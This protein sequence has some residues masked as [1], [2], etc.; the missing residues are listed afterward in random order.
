[1]LKTTFAQTTFAENNICSKQH[2]LKQYL[3]KTTFAQNN[4]FSKQYFLETTFAQNNI[5]SKKGKKEARKLQ[6]FAAVA[7]LVLVISLV[8]F[9]FP[10]TRASYPHQRM[11]G[12]KN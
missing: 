7:L 9:I 10:S 1:M 8:L 2:L 3:L 11:F 5:C 6:I 4:I 12:A